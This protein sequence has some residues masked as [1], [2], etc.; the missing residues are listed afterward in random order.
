MAMRVADTAADCETWRL[1]AGLVWL[2]TADE[3]EAL[4]RH[5]VESGA[6]TE[7][8]LIE[9]AGREVARRVQEHF[10]VGPVVAVA[11]RGHNGADS[12]VALRTLKRWGREVRA[13]Q[14]GAAPQPDVLVGSGVELS[15]VSEL[16]RACAGA[17]VVL[18]GIL[19]TGAKGPPREPLASVIGRIGEL[20]VPVLAVDGPSGADFTTGEV[21]GACVRAAVTVCLGWPNLGLLRYPARAYCGRLE[22]VEI[23]FP[24]PASPMRARAITG[25]W[26]A[27]TLIPR[28]PD[29]HKGRA[30][31]LSLLAGREGMAGAA[32]LGARAALRGGA[33]IL[34]VLGHP[35]NREIL[36]KTA[37][38]AIFV[39]WDDP[40]AVSA[41]VLW[42][43]ALAIGPGLGRDREARRLIDLVLQVRGGRPVVVDADGLSA[44]AGD[45][46]GLAAALGGRDVITPHPGELASLIGAG[47]ETIVSDPLAA[48]EDAA[49]RFGC[50][51]VLKG[52][53]S[54]VA[55]KGQPLRVSTTGS[56]AVA[57]GGTGDVL[58]GVIGAYLAA[59]MRAADAAGAALF[60]TGLA[61]RR[62]VDPVG[63]L[64]SDV[65][66]L[67]PFVRAEVSRLDPPS[68]PLIFVSEP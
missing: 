17:A 31:Y 23:G 14:A 43:G 9:A 49:E 67:I 50:V 16:E 52:A 48:A 26:V 62:S 55:E 47:V 24:P 28:A 39:G 25:R 22:A 33:G 53:P 63:H 36:Q 61:A 20:G 37:P 64:A 41:S 57:S 65:P 12:L 7:R 46:S 8:A 10:P 19:G 35:A 11:G 56:A 40:E 27:E 59:G 68:G 54:L 45:P 18:D 58:T 32:V 5:A 38:G 6:S 15:P 30:G 21:P 1:G 3:M 66:D 42:A 29:S 13:V 34:K 51:V 60:I 4:D 2:P 44:Y